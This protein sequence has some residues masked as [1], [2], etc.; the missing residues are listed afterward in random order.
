MMMSLFA[1]NSSAVLTAVER[2][3]RSV[4]T[5]SENFI[6]FS[7]VLLYTSTSWGSETSDSASIWVKAW[8]PDPMIPTVGEVFVLAKYLAVTAVVAPVLS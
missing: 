5:V 7:G 4:D 2:I 1:T 8:L 3:P 6:R